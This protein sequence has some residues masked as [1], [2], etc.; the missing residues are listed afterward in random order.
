MRWPC[1]SSHVVRMRARANR[2]DQCRT[3]AA[4]ATSVAAD[5]RVGEGHVV[6]PDGSVLKLPAD[7]ERVERRNEIVHRLA[8]ALGPCSR[9]VVRGAERRLFVVQPDAQLL[10]TIVHEELEAVP[11]VGDELA[12][13]VTDVL[14][15]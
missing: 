4:R 7:P 5:R 2:E 15:A 10:G 6:E 8:L 12:T 1:P 14:L 3:V 9:R 13:L 11:G